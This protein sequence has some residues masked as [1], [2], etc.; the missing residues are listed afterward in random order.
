MSNRGEGSLGAILTLV[1]LAAIGGFMF[2]LNQQTA[3][4]EDERA[5][6]A[7]AEAELLRDLTAG[8]LLSDP[9]GAVGRRTVIDSIR[10]QAG[11][12]AGAF[13]I[14]LS[15]STNYPVL[16]ESDPIQRLRMANINLFGGDI[17]YVSGQIFTFNDSIS[18]A[19]IEAGAVN[20]GMGDQIPSSPT[21]LYAD[22]VIVR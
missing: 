19:W 2:W 21:F 15:G 7:A 9:A 12:G 14:E 22:S 6:A 11:L 13:S 1:A 17:V 5:A 20:D 8:D 4:I 16:M 18:N 10:V 3:R